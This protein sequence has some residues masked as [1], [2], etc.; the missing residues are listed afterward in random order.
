MVFKELARSFW[1]FL[2]GLAKERITSCTNCTSA[3]GWK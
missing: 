2:G 1:Y 3:Q